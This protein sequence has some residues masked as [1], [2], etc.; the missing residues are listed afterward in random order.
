MNNYKGY[1]LFEDIEDIDLRTRNRAV[2]LANIYEDNPHL[3]DNTS[4][5]KRGALL[6]F[7]YM[8]SIPEGERAVTLESF[9][10]QM[11]SRGYQSVS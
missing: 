5:S 7:G 8:D 1:S 2:V 9:Y 10:E 4:T 11:E 6:I 3:S